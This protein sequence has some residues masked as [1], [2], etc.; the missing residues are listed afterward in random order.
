MQPASSTQVTPG[1]QV[2]LFSAH[3]VAHSARPGTGPLNRHLSSDW[4]QEALY[5]KLVCRDAKLPPLAA[6]AQRLLSF[7]ELNDLVSKIETYA[8]PCRLT[9]LA[10]ALD[11]RFEFNGLDNLKP[12]G[13]RPVV[14]FGNHPT[15]GGN[16]LGMSILLAKHF[17]DYRILGNR[18]M[19]FLP[20]LADRMIPVDP[21]FSSATVNLDSLL[22]LR[23][24]F[25]TKYQALGVFPAGVSSQLKISQGIITD[26]R[27]SDAF[28][29]IARHHDGMLVPIWFSGRNRLRYYLAAKLRTELGFLALA[30]EFLRLGGQ[31]IAVNIG[32]PISPEMLRHIH[33]RGAQLNFLRAGVYELGRGR[34]AKPAAANAVRRSCVAIGRTIEQPRALD[35]AA[36]GKA[37][38]ART[39]ESAACTRL[40]EF[41]GTAWRRD[42]TPATYHV[43]LT[44]PDRLEPRAYWQVLDWGQLTRQEL[45]RFSPMRRAFRLP[46]A[47]ADSSRHWLEI[48]SFG[49]AEEFGPRVAMRQAWIALR[50]HLALSPTATGLVGMLMP[51]ETNVAVAS[52]QLAILQKS[53]GDAALL[54]AHARAEL[55]GAPRH[56]DWRPGRDIAASGRQPQANQQRLIDPVLRNLAKM[57]VR[58]GAVGLSEDACPRPCILGRFDGMAGGLVDGINP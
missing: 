28:V 46:E 27:W 48:V 21:F 40:A 34:A 9:A 10:D 56:N 23:R 19:K 42:L 25:G 45:D 41:A 52:L 54:R 33:G 2:S 13:D 44:P 17:P 55:I 36:I 32:K 7:T 24:D 3:S 1:N 14:L 30:A 39:F 18:H 29:R 6:L 53:F 51:Q 11:V 4:L 31:T 43:V 12:I 38:E 22:G 37:L 26:R 15:G 35:G 57:G 50:R 58:F 20:A 16:V 47:I 8:H 49:V 5:N